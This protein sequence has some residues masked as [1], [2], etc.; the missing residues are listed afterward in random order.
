MI[1][2]EYSLKLE[3]GDAIS[4]KGITAQIAKIIYQDYDQ[5]RNQFIAEFEDTNGVLRSLHQSIDGGEVV[6]W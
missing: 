6:V 2:T 3:P 4:C 1:R 5:H